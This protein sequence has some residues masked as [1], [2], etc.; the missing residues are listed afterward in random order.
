M[1]IPQK[2]CPEDPVPDSAS[3]SSGA[4]ERR[5]RYHHFREITT[6]WEDNDVYG[7]VNNV[8]YYSFFDTAANC[9]LIEAGGLDIEASGVI[10]VVVESKCNYR[11]SAAFP[12][13]LEAG[14]R[15]DRIGNSSVRYGIGIFKKDE[16][17][18]S[19]WGHFVHVFVD[20]ETRKPVP[21]PADIR[22][23]LERIRA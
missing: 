20:R 13:V 17:E 2:T 21:I 3:S 16:D 8:V 7:H 11:R 1:L 19:A 12:E 14:L 6:R 9:Y 18:V 5:N 10:G 23:A 22:A 15:A 4:V